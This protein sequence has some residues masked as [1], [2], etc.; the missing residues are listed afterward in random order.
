LSHLTLANIIPETFEK[1]L[2]PVLRNGWDGLQRLEIKGVMKQ[3]LVDMRKDLIE[4]R[5]VLVGDG[6]ET[7][8]AEDS[9]ANHPVV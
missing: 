7:D 9:H 4:R 2:L 6:W 5:V 3:I 8:F 1:L